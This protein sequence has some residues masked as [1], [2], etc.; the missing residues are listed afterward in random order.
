MF[1]KELVEICTLSELIAIKFFC[2]HLLH[3]RGNRTEARDLLA[4]I[5]E[6]FAEGFDTPVF[7][8]A[9]ALLD[10]LALILHSVGELI[11]ISSNH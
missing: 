6:W 10:R 4:P 3:D 1:G 5:H 7:K 8:D 9:K 11:S 2:D